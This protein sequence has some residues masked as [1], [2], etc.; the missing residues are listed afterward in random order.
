MPARMVANAVIGVLVFLS[1]FVLYEPAPSDLLLCAVVVV[2]AFLGLRLSRPMLP[3]IV[4]MLLYMSGGLLSFVE[5]KA[6]QKPAIYMATTGFLAISSMFFAA[7]IQ[8]DTERRLKVIEQSYIAAAIVTAVLGILGYF[9]AIPYAEL[10][11][12]YDRAKGAF[13]D[14]NVFGPFLILPLIVLTRAVLTDKLANSG[15]RLLGIGIL[16]AGVFLSFSRAAWGMAIVA[17]LLITVLAFVS[18]PRQSRRLRMIAYIAGGLLAVALL[19]ALLLS[20][21]LVQDLFAQRFK[22]VQEYD[23]GRLGRF[24]RHILGFFLIQEHPFG[25]GPFEFGKMMGEDEHNMWLKGFTAYGWLGGVSYIALVVWTLL[26]ATP[27]LFRARPWTPFIQSVYAVYIGHLLIH[28]VIDNDHWRHLFLIYGLLWG[29][30]ALEWK[31]RRIAARAPPPPLVF[32]PV[33]L[34]RAG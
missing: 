18:E 3:M 5:L 24:E 9:G 25:L 4:L 14:P 34:P 2:W 32:G 20:I 17:L 30:Y 10:F 12:L 1:G 7:V 21:P 6:F 16:L 23:A 8:T 33:A 29:A 26:I 31:N 28:N 19:L 22:L 11:T 27:L 15:W 13:K